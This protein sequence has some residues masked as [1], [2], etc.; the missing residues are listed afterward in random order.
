MELGATRPA[1][2]NQALVGGMMD[3]LNHRIISPSG[4]VISAS[5]TNGYKRLSLR[6]VLAASFGTLGL[7]AALASSLAVGKIADRRI[8]A[9]IGAEFAAAAER[10]AD[11]LDRGLF[12]R[13]RDV[14]VAAS[15]DAMADGKAAPASR[16][17]VLRRLQETYPD[18][19]ILLF[20]APDGRIQATS[21]GILT[22]ADVSQREYFR[23]GA[24]GPFVADVHE[25]TLMAPFLGR[26]PDN[27]PRFVDLSAP[28]RAP[29]G[30]MIGVVAA[31]L[32][33]E[34]AE[35][36]G[37][38]VMAP[39]LAR[40]PGAE[41]I[42]FSRSGEVL[43]GPPGLRTASL[44]NIAPDVAP[45]LA[46]GRTGSNVELG[47]P[48][49]EAASRPYLVGY[50]ATH[51]HRSYPGLGWTVVVRR[52]AEVA[53]APARRLVWTVMAWGVAAAAL[54][55]ALG[56]LL[57]GLI[58]RPL[59]DLSLA[60]ERLKDDPAATEVPTGR[61]PREIV[62]LSSALATL[63]AGVRWRE[64][65]LRLGE[66]RLRM[67]TEGA[68]IGTWELDLASG[69]SV[70]S[71]RHD[72][73]FGHSP[74]LAE[75]TF[76]T[77]AHHLVPEDRSAVAAAFRHAVDTGAEWYLECRIRPPET[78]EERWIQ[79]RGVPLS[80]PVTGATCR[81]SGVVEDITGRKEG[82]RA[83]QLLVR[84]LDHRVKNQFA[85]F[86][87]LV[88]FTA[89]AA[90]DPAS[91]AKV[92]RSR[93]HA[94]AAAHDLVR[95]ATGDGPTRGLR[96]TTLTALLE[97]IL[98]PFGVVGAQTLCLAPHRVRLIGPDLGVGP[99]SA[100]ALALVIHELATNAARHGALSVPAG[101]VQVS[102]LSTQ[103]MVKIL[104]HESGGPLIAGE[105]KH[106]GFGTTLIDQGIRAQLG[107]TVMFEW[108][109]HEGISVTLNL[110]ADRLAR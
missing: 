33:W 11:L 50:A 3:A 1:A 16:Q 37:R 6:A 25:A 64:A 97:A 24:E 108:L 105:P 52:D 71:P 55:A 14:Q 20:I 29:D 27:P 46:A 10:L 104:W 28:V 30:A 69:Q 2:L 60:A 42:V 35:G 53:F 38:H 72:A 86:D 45:E 9:D 79:I 77:F 32:F 78:G 59:A 67:A 98:A 43:L 106:R 84:E 95:D 44:L 21:S 40:H 34:W 87:S 70:R 93:L 18:Y 65:A 15:L 12:E 85:V 31:H 26:G 47:T 8:R 23:R 58:S 82:E 51:G 17:A 75:W 110:P 49:E 102:W 74:Q 107:G 76:D 99:C 62:S 4:Q 66:A 101:M 68:G 48:K 96:P 22:G 100:S 56:W 88:Q 63:V 54:A 5:R 36:I 103:G 81:Y 91:M 13:L 92:L 109:S 83:L 39:L 57:A 73:I 7:V 89:R 90:P 41:A 19:A 61:G 94:L 80:D